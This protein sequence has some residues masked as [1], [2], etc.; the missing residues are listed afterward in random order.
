MCE[1]FRPVDTF[2]LYLKK[3]K[4]LNFTRF[5]FL[6]DLDYKYKLMQIESIF[7]QKTNIHKNVEN[8]F[9]NLFTGMLPI[10]MNGNFSLDNLIFLHF[11]INRHNI[12]NDSLEKLG[13]TKHNLKSPL[14][15]QF[16]GEEGSDEGG[17]RN[18]F[19]QLVTK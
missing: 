7:E 16:I 17:V 5:P 8:G 12:L 18:E 10:D 3:T 2:K 19:F 4:P 15:I 6:L 11:Q 1:Y 14:K 13:K 9:Q